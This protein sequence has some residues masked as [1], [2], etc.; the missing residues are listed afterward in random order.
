MALIQMA[1][2]EEACHGLM[3][4]V[5][6]KNI[7]CGFLFFGIDFSINYEL[8]LNRSFHHMDDFIGIIVQDCSRVSYGCLPNQGSAYRLKNI[9]EK[10][11]KFC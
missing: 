5:F 6:V 10:I 9:R 1:T 7:L 3:V 2:V 11:R 4:S 8:I